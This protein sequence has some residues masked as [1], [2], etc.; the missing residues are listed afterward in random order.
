M[1][2]PSSLKTSFEASGSDD[3]GQLVHVLERLDELPGVVRLAAGVFTAVPA[4]LAQVIVDERLR[5]EVGHA[6]G[7]LDDALG[8]A[9]G[10]HLALR[11]VAEVARPGVAWHVGLKRAHAVG[12]QL[13][14][15]R[16][17][18]AGQVGR[19]ATLLRFD[20]QGA[21]GGDEVCDV[22]DVHA[23]HPGRAVFFV[24]RVELDDADGIIE[25]LGVGRVDGDDEVF[26][27][28]F[29]VG[30]DGFADA[31][32]GVA[33]LVGDVLGEG[34]G[35]A[36][37]VHD[38]VGLD[39][40]LAGF[41]Q[42]LRDDAL[43]EFVV[44]RLA[45]GQQLDDDLGVL[46]GVGAADVSDEDRIAEC[47]TVGDDDP[48]LAFAREC[49]G[50][51]SLSALDD[52]DDDAC[53][54]RAVPAGG[55]AFL[56]G[57]DL[58][59]DA[60]AGHGVGG[61]AG[62]DEQVA[63]LDELV[64]H[65]EA[66]AVGV[67]PEQADDELARRGE[68]DRAFIAAHDLPKF[69]ELGDGGG[70]VVSVFGVDRQGIR[71]VRGLER[72]VSSVRQVRKDPLRV[73]VGHAGMVAGVRW[74]GVGSGCWGV[75]NGKKSKVQCPRSNV[76]RSRSATLDLRHSDLRPLPTPP[77]RAQ[78]RQVAVLF[79]FATVPPWPH[80]TRSLKTRRHWASS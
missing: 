75:V 59:S 28:V 61:V 48:E 64:G 24:S 39:I 79:L 40:G 69:D 44:G 36:E 4:R 32:G 27:E 41:A 78:A 57:E 18:T 42:D 66:E 50:V 9:F 2:R 56:V 30:G 45:V 46:G 7:G 67:L 60:V 80:S 51:A 34:H 77:T 3:F 43:G 38:R 14:Q 8:E 6:V 68:A 47:S 33:C 55:A 20:V 12:Q 13:G 74:G 70:E 25:V 63:V 65:E 58:G 10:E 53:E 76:R 5:F 19:V 31:F 62:R 73:A 54:G 16:H 35:Q 1:T 26:G 52:F 71:E 29:A 17:D 23:E 22:G 49:A 21:A 11:V 72:A 15:H 37:G